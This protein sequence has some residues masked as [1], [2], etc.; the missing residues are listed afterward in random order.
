MAHDQQVAQTILQQ[1]GGRRF[2]AMT[3]ASSFSS[4]PD[5]L[6]FRVPTRLAGGIGGIVITLTQMDDYRIESVR[7]RGSIAKG[8]LR[9]ER[10][11]EAEG[12]YCDNLQEAFTRITG[13]ATSLGSMG[14]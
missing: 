11:V 7:M 1:L 12:V 2:I 5:S 13:L 10:K 4:G 6:G 3:G 9:A 8:D 14:R